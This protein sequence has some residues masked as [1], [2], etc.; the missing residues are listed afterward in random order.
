MTDYRL[1]TVKSGMKIASPE[2]DI[3]LDV[4]EQVI[5]SQFPLLKEYLIKEYEYTFTSNP[6]VGTTNIISETHDLDYVPSSM[7]FKIEEWNSEDWVLALPIIRTDFIISPA[8]SS[9]LYVRYYVD[10]TDIKIYIVKEHFGTFG[11]GDEVRTNVNGETWTFK[12][13]IFADPGS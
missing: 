10:D 9:S 4:D 1:K 13:F 2:G 7:A 8:G 5:H 11:S 3:F 6:G 12:L